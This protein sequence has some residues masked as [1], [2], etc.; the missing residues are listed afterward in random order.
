MPLASSRA[1]YFVADADFAGNI[2]HAARR[3]RLDLAG[4][5][6]RADA[7]RPGAPVALRPTGPNVPAAPRP[8]GPGTRSA[9]RPP[10]A[11]Q[12]PDDRAADVLRIV[13]DSRT[14]VFVTVH[15]G[16]RIRYGYWRPV[17]SAAGRGGCYVALPSDVCEEL[18]SGGHIELG[19]PVTDP[20]KTTYRVRR[21][22]RTVAE[23][24]AI[25]RREEGRAA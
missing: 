16:G 13:A 25:P 8:S 2:V 21:T 17:D 18:R 5:T 24:K 9:P 4:R 7:S 19:E 3:G 22:A 6:P 23:P 14:P 20:S 15:E 1:P 10:G 12:S 11:R